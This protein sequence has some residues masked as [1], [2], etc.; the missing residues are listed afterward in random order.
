MDITIGEYR[1]YESGTIIAIPNEPVTFKI[2]N[3]QFKLVFTNTED[4]Q[5]KLE[6]SPVASNTLQLTFLNFNNS[7]GTGNTVPLPLGRL[8]EEELFFQ[9]RIYTLGDDTG[10]TIHYTWLTKPI[11]NDNIN[12]SDNGN[13]VG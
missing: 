13:L 9:F 7:L 8:G 2:K 3:L 1:V 4:K 12:H 11:Q 6:A 10:K 5:Q